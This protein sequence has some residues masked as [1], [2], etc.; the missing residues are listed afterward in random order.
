[1]KCMEQDSAVPGDPL[2]RR[3]TSFTL[4]VAITAL[5]TLAL[6]AIASAEPMEQAAPK[7][8]KESLCMVDA[9]QIARPRALLLG[10][11]T[12]VTLTARTL[13]TGF[14]LPLHIVLVVDPSTAMGSSLVRDLRDYLETLVTRLNLKDNPGTKVA[15]VVVD[16]EARTYAPL[17]NDMGRVMGAI[18]RIQAVGDTRMELGLREGVREILRGRQTLTYTS[19]SNDMIVVLSDGSNATGCRAAEQA[20]RDAKNH[21]ILVAAAC[22]GR[23]CSHSC[24][25]GIGSSRRYYFR[26]DDRSSLSDV[27]RRILNSDVRITIRRLTIVETLPPNMRYVEGSADPEPEAISP[28][29][30]SLRWGLNFVPSEGITLTYRIQPQAPGSHPTS[31]GAAVSFVDSQALGGQ[32]NL[33][34]PQ[35]QVL[36]PVVVPTATPSLSES[37]PPLP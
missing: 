14:Y 30:K 33:P 23:G 16:A 21:G 4:A 25:Q 19:W 15:V 12:E 7:P 31:L 32:L 8:P 1:M 28:D 17:T 36:A 29:G 18:G 11:T 34:S 2:L 10:E 5:A 22:V 20:A 26:W 27:F 35:V 6:P 24:M 13:C 37:T 3:V 9:S